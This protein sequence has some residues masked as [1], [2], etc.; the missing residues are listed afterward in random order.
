MSSANPTESL[1]GAN[2]LPLEKLTKDAKEILAFPSVV[3]LLNISI[4]V[5]RKARGNRIHI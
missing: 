4:G 5:L 2:D 3:T 1:L